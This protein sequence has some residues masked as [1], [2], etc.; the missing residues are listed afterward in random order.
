M[1]RFQFRLQQVLKWKEQR[2]R[3]SELVLSKARAELET[4]RLQISQLGSRLAQTAASLEEQVGQ[5]VRNPDLSRERKAECSW[6]WKACC[7]Y[8]ARLRQD[9]QSAQADLERAAHKLQEACQKHAR[10]ATEVEALRYLYRRDYGQHRRDTLRGQQKTLDDLM[11][12]R[13]WG[14]G[15]AGY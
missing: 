7:D 11:G 9:L 12:L 13:A 4:A 1:K 5:T 15:S 3:Q 8:S 2:Q 14:L 10:I 6:L